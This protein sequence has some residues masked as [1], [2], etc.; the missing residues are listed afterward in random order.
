[1]EMIDKCVSLN[2][3]ACLQLERYEFILMTEPHGDCCARSGPFY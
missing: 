1:M 2:D 3:A